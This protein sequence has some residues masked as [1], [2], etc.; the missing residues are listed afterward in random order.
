MSLSRI[1]TIIVG[2]SA[3]FGLML[4]LISSLS[5][6]YSEIAWT[7]PFLANFFSIYSHCFTDL[8]YCSFYLL[9]RCHPQQQREG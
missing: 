5:R 6:L 1:I 7:S 3:I 8:L 9:F 2:I 4:W